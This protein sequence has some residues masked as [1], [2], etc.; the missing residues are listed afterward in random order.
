MEEKKKNSA[1]EMCRSPTYKNKPNRNFT[2]RLQ[3]KTFLPYLINST[4][5]KSKANYGLSVSLLTKCTRSQIRK[6]DHKCAK[7]ANF[8]QYNLFAVPTNFDIL[9]SQIE[10]PNAIPFFFV[11]LHRN[12]V[13]LHN[14]LLKRFLLQF[15]KLYPNTKYKYILTIKAN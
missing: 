9:S 2:P 14:N 8:R 10:F 5:N 12:C 11:G 1:A 4:E 15:L 3:K 13:K 6:Q 7:K